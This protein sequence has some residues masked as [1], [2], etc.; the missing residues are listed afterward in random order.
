MALHLA[1]DGRTNEGLKEKNA[2]WK[3]VW[4]TLLSE[5]E[6]SSPQADMKHGPHKIIAPP[7]Y[8]YQ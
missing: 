7:S 2:C 8:T 4:S 6:T 1:I 5:N 3:S